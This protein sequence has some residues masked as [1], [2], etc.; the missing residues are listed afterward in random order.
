[1]LKIASI[2]LVLL[3]PA[4]VF[5]I[6]RPEPVEKFDEALHNAQQCAVAEDCTV[7]YTECPFGCSHPVATDALP[8]LTTLA[9]KLVKEHRKRAKACAYDCGKAPPVVCQARRCTF[10]ESK[11][12]Q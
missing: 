3:I 1:M 2:V 4:L 8:E 11:E 9:K 7:M 5:W 6:H 10:A 12:S